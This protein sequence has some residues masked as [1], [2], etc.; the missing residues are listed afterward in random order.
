MSTV[1]LPLERA[2]GISP[3]CSWRKTADNWCPYA[4]LFLTCFLESKLKTECWGKQKR[5]PGGAAFSEFSSLAEAGVTLC[6]GFSG[7]SY[8]KN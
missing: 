8:W 5:L 6:L 1:I 3:L 2:K 4:R 7:F